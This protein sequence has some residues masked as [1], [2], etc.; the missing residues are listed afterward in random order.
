MN[1]TNDIFLNPSNDFLEH[2]DGMQ[3]NPF[4]VFY[5]T[6]FPTGNIPMD[7]MLNKTTNGSNGIP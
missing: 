5:R 4:I 6:G 2:P 7:A 1:M 3:L